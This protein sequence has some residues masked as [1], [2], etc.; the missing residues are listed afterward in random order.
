M[1]SGCNGAN[2]VAA[3]LYR[4]QRHVAE[5]PRTVDRPGDAALSISQSG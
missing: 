4:F 3:V 5:V 2:R 1:T